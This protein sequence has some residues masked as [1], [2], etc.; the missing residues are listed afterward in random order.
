MRPPFKFLLCTMFFSLISVLSYV[1]LGFMDHADYTNYASTEI[2]SRETFKKHFLYSNI[3]ALKVSNN[4][5]SEG[6]ACASELFITSCNNPGMA[7][8]ILMTLDHISLVVK[9]E[10]HRRCSGEIA[11]LSV[12]GMPQS[13]RGKCSSSLSILT[14]KKRQRK[15]CV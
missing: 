1:L 2:I 7:A 14:S 9:F 15:S 12:Q 10:L 3:I 4:I 5:F 11:A 8:M 13:T 6:F